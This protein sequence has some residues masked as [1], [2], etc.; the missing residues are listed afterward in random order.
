VAPFKIDLLPSQLQEW[1]RDVCERMQCPSDFIG[2]SVMVALGSVIGPRITIRPQQNSTEWTEAA[3]LYGLIIG[4]PGFMK[5]P[6]MNVALASLKRLEHAAREC[7]REAM[8]RY[9]AVTELKEDS[10]KLART[11]SKRLMEGNAESGFESA[12]QNLVDAKKIVNESKPLQKRYIAN[13]TNPASLMELLRQNQ[14]G[15][16]NHYDEIKALFRSFENENTSELR[17]ILLSCWNGLASYTSDRINRGLDLH[18][19]NACLSVL[20]S[21]QPGVISP[22]IRAALS[23]GEGADGL[24]QRFQLMPNL[25]SKTRF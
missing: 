5:S 6:A 13:N 1:A 9:E 24:L 2:V 17:D 7:H 11:T 10:L 18:I 15:I 19:P 22:Y 3:N 4:R 14:N 25:N 21:I 12:V 23:E 20:G 8:M 16:L